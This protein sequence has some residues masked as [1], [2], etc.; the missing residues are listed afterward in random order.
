MV[1]IE[2]GECAPQRV[3]LPQ[4]LIYVYRL[5]GQAVMQACTGVFVGVRTGCL[6]GH[7]VRLALCYLPAW[8]HRQAG[9]GRGQRECSF[10]VYH[11]TT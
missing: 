5:R 11:G 2:F 10:H 8:A 4:S 6:Q 7:T 3:R 1:L 9:I